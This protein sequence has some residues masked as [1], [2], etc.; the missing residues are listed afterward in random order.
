M[1]LYLEKL[2]NP[3]F[4]IEKKKKEIK[5]KYKKKK[6]ELHKNKKN[7]IARLKQKLIDYSKEQINDEV[8]DKINQ[9]IYERIDQVIDYFTHEAELLEQLEEHE[10]S[11]IEKAQELY[12]KSKKIAAAVVVS[13]IIITYANK[14]YRAHRKIA[15]KTC[16]KYTGNNFKKCMK[17]E[18]MIALKLKLTELNKQVPRCNKSLDPYECKARVHRH[19]IK[20]RDK[21]V[22]YAEDMGVINL[23]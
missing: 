6:E 13:A 19:Y 21:L 22:A 18:R 17:R 2:Q 16:S 5:A 9:R 7:I 11:K 8:A 23:S 4:S 15:K 20:V 1:E 14:I 10:L 12:Y 3:D